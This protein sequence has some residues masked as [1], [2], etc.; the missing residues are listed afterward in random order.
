M[1]QLIL[2]ELQNNFEF[3]ETKFNEGKEK[4][5]WNVLGHV[6]EP[7]VGGDQKSSFAW[8]S[9]DP[10]GTF[11]PPHMHPVQDEHAFIIEGE[12]ALYLDGKW[13][14][15]R[16]GDYLYWPRGTVHGYKIVSETP[17]KGIFWVSPGND[18]ASLF[19]ELHN[20]TE[21]EEVVR[22]SALR[23][24]RFIAPDKLENYE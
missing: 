11:V 4:I 7:M 17:G 8:I 1:N 3:G 2:T 24:I 5:S 16:A 6:Y 9:N 18:L 20:L 22:V 15:A 13:S 21:P 14:I 10:P 12:Y 19:S 23:N